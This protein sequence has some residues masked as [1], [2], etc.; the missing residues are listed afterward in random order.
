MKST[1][2]F[3]ENL[4]VDERCVKVSRFFVFLEESAESV[5]HSATCRGRAPGGYAV[6]A[7][8]AIEEGPQT[9]GK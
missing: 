8:E 9:R 4:E 6:A 3:S 1:M 5:R 7:I 2:L